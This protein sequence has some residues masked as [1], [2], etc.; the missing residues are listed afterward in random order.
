MSNMFALTFQKCSFA[1][2][3]RF[4]EHCSFSSLRAVWILSN[5]NRIL[6]DQIRIEEKCYILMLCWVRQA[7]HFK[8]NISIHWDYYNSI[9]FYIHKSCF[10]SNAWSFWGL[11]FGFPY[12][13][14]NYL[15][16]QYILRF[17]NKRFFVRVSMYTKITNG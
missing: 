1:F 17:F 13:L 11:I 3:F 5:F 9:Y 12:Y 6:V 2:I 8:W 16:K 10:I 14:I 7:S 4:K 15:Q